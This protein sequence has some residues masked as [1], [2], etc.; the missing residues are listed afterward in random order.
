MRAY[1]VGEKGSKLQM[2]PGTFKA[3]REP[4]ATI[5]VRGLYG[6]IIKLKPLGKLICPENSRTGWV[7]GLDGG[8]VGVAHKLHALHGVQ[9]VYGHEEC[10]AA[11]NALHGAAC[12]ACRGKS[13]ERHRDAKVGELHLALRVEQHVRRLDV[14]VQHAVRREVRE[15][16][17]AHDCSGR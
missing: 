4:S 2:D 13:W 14:G 10:G 17:D 8:V 11:E 5:D 12:G 1:M 6:G 3:L 16:R 15:R 7:G 9:T